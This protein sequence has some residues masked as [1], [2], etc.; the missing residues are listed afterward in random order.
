MA[1]SLN[2]V[3]TIEENINKTVD[4]ISKIEQALSRLGTVD[5]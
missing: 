4:N 2:V 5:L 3:N 1:A